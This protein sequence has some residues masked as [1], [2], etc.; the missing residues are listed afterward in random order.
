MMRQRCYYR[1][2]TSCLTPTRMEKLKSIGFPLDCPNEKS[3]DE[4]NWNNR[5]QQLLKFK[6]KHGH[7][8]VSRDNGSRSLYTW[9]TRQR[10]YYRRGTGCLTP[11]RIEELESIGFSLDCPLKQSAKKGNSWRS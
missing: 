5:I 4:T 1:R 2:G 9:M 6:E 3:A 8:N 7:F 11:A 10:W